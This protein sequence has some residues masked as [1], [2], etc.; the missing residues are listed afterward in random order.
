MDSFEAN[1]QAFIIR[2][3]LEPRDDSQAT[4]EWRGLIEHAPTRQRRYFKDWAVVS[5]F[6]EQYLVQMGIRVSWRWR[7]RRWV[8]RLLG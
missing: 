3:W 2:I 1:T 7:L 8:N 4:P 6:V 5:D